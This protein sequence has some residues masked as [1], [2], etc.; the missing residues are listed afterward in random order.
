MWKVS[1]TQMRMSE[2]DYGITLPV[3]V[4]GI[5]LGAGDTLRYTFKNAVNQDVIL[6]KDFDNITENTV[7]FVLTAAES[8][9]FSPGAY[10]YSLDWY[11]DGVFL[12]NLV[13]VGKFHVG[14]KA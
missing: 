1:G 6:V 3:V 13:E 5:T 8:A 9:L 10:V 7:N 11:Q 12:C 4:S 14:D 2:G